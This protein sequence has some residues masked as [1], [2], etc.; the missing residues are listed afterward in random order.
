MISQNS[1]PVVPSMKGLE[2]RQTSRKAVERF[3]YINIEPGNGGSV[4]NVSE[5][6][7]CF[8]ADAPVE[9]NKTIRLWFWNHDRRIEIQGSLVWMDEKLKTG[10]LRFTDLPV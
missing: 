7:L 1:L 5:G 4:L 3:A 2:R 9:R 6:G 8:R 10:G